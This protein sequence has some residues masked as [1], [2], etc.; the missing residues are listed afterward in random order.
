MKRAVLILLLTGFGLAV[1]LV[2]GGCGGSGL[3]KGS[4]IDAPAP[5]GFVDYCARHPQRAECGG[6]E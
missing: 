3:L 4:G 1:A 6:T 2:L 5:S